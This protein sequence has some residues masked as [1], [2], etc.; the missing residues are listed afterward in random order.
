MVP[1]LSLG[2][3]VTLRG[4][5]H[6]H[7][8][9]GRHPQPSAHPHGVE[10]VEV[11]TGGR[12]WVHDAGTWREVLPGDVAWHIEG[13]ETIGRSDFTN[14]YRCLAV[15]FN[16]TGPTHRRLPRFSRWDDLAD[17]LAY[18]RRLVTDVADERI[19]RPLLGRAVYSRL[20]LVV[21]THLL[22]TRTDL[23]AALTR[24]L[25]LV[26]RDP[27]AGLMVEDLAAAA[28]WSPTH[29]HAEFRAHLGTS[30][31]QWLLERR[32]RAARERLVA[33]DDGLEAIASACGFGTAAALCRRFRVAMG[34]SPGRYRESQR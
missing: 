30:P 28:G 5:S 18:T 34:V 11:V 13:D 19:D 20:Q 24:A 32:L 14:P 29:F 2:H 15:T 31:H 26:E 1:D 17:L 27:V 8:Q 23:P 21:H 3:L 22:G 7:Q 6:Y 25:A 33:S 12:G 4:A 10:R 16:V 9:P